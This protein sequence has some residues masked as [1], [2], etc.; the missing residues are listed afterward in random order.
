MRRAWTWFLAFFHLDSA[1]VCEMSKGRQAWND[2]HDYDD[3]T[4]G[5]PDHFIPLTC[6]RCGKV[7]TI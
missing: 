4:F 3:S 7:F 5:M 6:K 2:F 1:A